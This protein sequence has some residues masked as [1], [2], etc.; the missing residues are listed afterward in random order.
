MRS[1]LSEGISEAAARSTAA[2]Y[3]PRRKL[4]EKAYNGDHCSAPKGPQMR[5]RLNGC[6]AIVA[7]LSPCFSYLLFLS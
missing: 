6:T 4:P 5:L 7:T 3:E 1:S 2:L